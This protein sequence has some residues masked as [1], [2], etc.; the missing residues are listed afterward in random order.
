MGDW[1]HFL[2]M[3]SGSSFDKK[4]SK[5]SDLLLILQRKINFKF[6]LERMGT[7][8]NDDERQANLVRTIAHDLKV[9]GVF[10]GNLK[11][12]FE[13]AESNWLEQVASGSVVT[14]FQI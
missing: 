9:L 8:E 11:P 4:T 7:N 1:D 12:L 3:I 5:I 10:D 14:D 13:K 6:R 2:L